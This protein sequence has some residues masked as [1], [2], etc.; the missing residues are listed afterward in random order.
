MGVLNGIDEAKK[1]ISIAEIAFLGR[2]ISAELRMSTRS[3]PSTNYYRLKF[4]D[5]IQSLKGTAPIS[6]EFEYQQICKFENFIKEDGTMMN[7]S[8]LKE[9]RVDHLYVAIYNSNEYTI[10]TL[11]E[12]NENDLPILS[13]LD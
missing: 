6:T 10:E 4:Q 8:D 2:L 12:I 11:I 1:E 13:Q 5:N 7:T 9:P 3:L